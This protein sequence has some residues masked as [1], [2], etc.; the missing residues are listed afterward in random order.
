MRDNKMS[1]PNANHFK[2]ILEA[3][4]LARVLGIEHEPWMFH[5]FKFCMAKNPETAAHYIAKTKGTL[6]L[7]TMRAAL[8]QRIPQ[9]LFVPPTESLSVGT[10]VLSR[11]RAAMH[12]DVLARGVM[13]ICGSHSDEMFAYLMQLL[14]EM[15]EKGI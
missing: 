12:K 10:E 15:K 9:W 1:N 6:T 14:G 3:Q 2:E 5:H 13:L 7:M 4:E 8:E 11:R